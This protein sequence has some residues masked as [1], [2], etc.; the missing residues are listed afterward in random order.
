MWLLTGLENSLLCA[1]IFFNEVSKECTLYNMHSLIPR[2]ISQVFITCS[3]KSTA[4]DKSL[5]AKPGNEAT[6][7]IFKIPH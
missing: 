7:S 4:S 5:G 6:L 2:L 3:M 1:L